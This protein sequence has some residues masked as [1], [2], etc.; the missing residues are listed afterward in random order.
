MN[1]K[2][3]CLHCREYQLQSSMLMLKAGSFCSMDHAVEY[4]KA[5]AGKV[6]EKQHKAQKAKV[7]LED[8][9]HQH[10]LTQSTV[11]RLC[12]LLDLGRPCI[13]CGK[14]DQGGKM[15]NAGHFKSRGSSSGL[16]YD[17]RNIHGQCVTC[18]LYQSGNIEGY[19]SGLTERY[20]SAIVDYLDSSPRVRSWKGPELAVLRSEISAEIRLIES[21]NPP[22][23]DWRA[24]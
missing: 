8:T 15:R 24:I 18:N 9:R 16:R 14:P 21:G 2:R 7:K 6:R 10:R 17:L 22:S 3:K 5:T 11:N 23:K 13:S 1:S 19:R 12:L 20:G 4:A